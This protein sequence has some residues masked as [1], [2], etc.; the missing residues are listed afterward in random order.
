MGIPEAQLADVFTPLVSDKAKGL[1]IGLSL[2]RQVLE[3]FAGR[4]A[5]TSVEGQGTSVTLTLAV[6]G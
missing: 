6:A 2:A 4:I 1:G 3:G 5:L